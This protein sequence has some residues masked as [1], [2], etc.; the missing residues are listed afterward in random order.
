[1][2]NPSEMKERL[3]L[4]IDQMETRIVELDKKRNT[5]GKTLTDMR[6]LYLKACRAEENQ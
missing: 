2:I 4:E 1:M 5:Y 6:L 3:K